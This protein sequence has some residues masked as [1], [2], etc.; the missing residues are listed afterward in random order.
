MKKL[1]L[2]IP[3]LFIL[4]SVSAQ[5]VDRDRVVVE[6]AT[7]TWCQYCPGAA[8][9]AEDLVA[10]GKEVAIVE[11]HGGDEYEN[12]HGASR[13]SYYSVTG[14]PTAV[15]DGILKVVGGDHT[16]SM[17][18]QYLP[19]YNQR[20]AVL[21]PFTIDVQGENTCLVN[22]NL[23]ITLN[24]VEAVTGTF[25]LHVAVTES[26]IQESW[27][28]MSEL[29]WVERRMVP[30]QNGTVLD[31]SSGDTQVINL[32]FVVEDSWVRENSELTVFI[33]N[34]TTKE[35]AQGIKMNLTD[36]PNT[37]LVDA[38]LLD[39]HNIGVSNCS[40]R[41]SPIVTLR[42]NGQND[43]TSLEIHYQVN[44]GEESI[45]NWTGNLAMGEIETAQLPIIT[46]PL[47]GQNTI[48]IF[49]KNPNDVTDECPDNDAVSSQ[50][51]DE[52]QVSSNTVY[53][54]YRLDN[55]P[56]QTTWELRD[57]T[58]AVLYADGPFPGQ[59]SLFAKDTFQLAGGQCYDF[60]IYDSQGN[61]ICCETG[62]GFYLLK[63]S[64]GL[65]LVQG[66]DFGYSDVISFEVS[67]GVGI[68]E[69]EDGGTAVHIYPNPASGQA[70]IDISLM[71]SALASIRIYSLTGEM[72]KSIDYG[73]LTPGEHQ[74]LLVTSGLDPGAYFVR[75][76]AGEAEWT[77]KLF[78][79]N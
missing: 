66:G 24:R 5:P 11:Y 74:I 70:N 2:L 69:K 61:G 19:K 78:I 75:I 45:Q 26:D 34:T 63:D 35:I 18:S 22:Y 71:E 40:G 65:V 58:G 67:G 43:L 1:Y 13:I 76:T 14:Y 36:F 25:K 79:L 73:V 37:T 64:D 28:G 27:Q 7:G 29:N 52:V 62:V 3:V 4:V 51:T 55:F 23:S 49:C 33:Q 60:I 10:N 56:E 59:P 48:N 6:I 32:S 20:I 50:F 54:T 41:V 31:F 53:L 72:I 77:K 17:Y 44:D 38:S 30:N 21:S 8:M 15:F 47:I 68:S 9:G 46:F 57:Q 39:V 16:Q 12:S 42:N